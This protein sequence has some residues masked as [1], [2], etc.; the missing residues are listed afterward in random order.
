MSDGFFKTTDKHI[1][2]LAGVVLDPGFWWSRRYEYPFALEG[3]KK[4]DVV[5][6]AACG[7]I[8][9][10]K[11]ALG[12][13]CKTHACDIMTPPPSNKY[14]FTW[15]NIGAMPY[16][17]KTFTKVFCISV[18]EHLP[19]DEIELVAKEFKRV[20][21]PK[22]KLILTVDFPTCDIPHLYWALKSA[23]FKTNEPDMDM[24]GALMSDYFG[25]EL[26]CYHIAAT[27]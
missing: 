27:A 5:L 20:L 1:D 12:D 8:H 7:D 16:K 15:A 4:T 22:G 6:D 24:T 3:V 25:R 10:L 11:L 26:W 23:G 13:I 18:L 14:E 9:P 2:E 17:D 19:L 21:K